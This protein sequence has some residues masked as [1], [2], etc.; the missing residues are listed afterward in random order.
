MLLL[1]P[2]CA[3]WTAEWRGLFLSVGPHSGS[4][5]HTL[6]PLRS[7]GLVQ[8][9]CKG[10]GI[11]GAGE[12]SWASTH[13]CTS[14]DPNVLNTPQASPSRWE[15][16]SLYKN[17][18]R[19]VITATSFTWNVCN[20]NPHLNRWK[21]KAGSFEGK[22]RKLLQTEGINRTNWWFPSACA[23]AW[24]RKPPS[25]I[26]VTATGSVRCSSQTWVRLKPAWPGFVTETEMQMSNSEWQIIAPRIISVI[27]TVLWKTQKEVM[28]AC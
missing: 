8:T 3:P 22:L 11:P 10:R 1:S 23:K 4:C 24:C 28:K 6:A 13:L 27:S 25:N 14:T 21:K 7:W 19:K 15:Q 2:V 9:G 12:L 5:A 17:H 20:S 16:I 18:A 26:W